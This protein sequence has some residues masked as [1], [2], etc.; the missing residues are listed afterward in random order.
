MQLESARAKFFLG[1]ESFLSV[2]IQLSLSGP[3]EILAFI[4]AKALLK[5]PGLKPAQVWWVER[6]GIR[7]HKN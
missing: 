7:L 2:G 3:I 5:Q 6:F 1:S 4:I